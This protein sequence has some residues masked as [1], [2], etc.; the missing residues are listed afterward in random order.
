MANLMFCILRFDEVVLKLVDVLKV[1]RVLV[2]YAF[3]KFKLLSCTA[4]AMMLYSISVTAA[5]YCLFCGKP[6]IFS[7]GKY[8]CVNQYCRGVSRSN[9]GSPMGTVK[10]SI[11]TPGYSFSIQG[12]GCSMLPT[13][14]PT[15]PFQPQAIAQLQPQPQLQLQPQLQPQPNMLLSQQTQQMAVASTTAPSSGDTTL[16]MAQPQ[17]SSSKLSSTLELLLKDFEIHLQRHSDLNYSSNSY[18][19]LLKCFV[20]TWTHLS[21]NNQLN[22]VQTIR[23]LCHDLDLCGI[24]PP[25]IASS[26]PIFNNSLDTLVNDLL[27]NNQVLVAF[28]SENTPFIM[29]HVRNLEG[30]SASL[31]AIQV[32]GVYQAGG[33]DTI[34]SLESLRN[35]LFQLLHASHQEGD[36][37]AILIFRSTTRSIESSIKLPI[38]DK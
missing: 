21:T 20:A 26:K 33:F 36:N 8:L 13:F 11:Q 23:R 24:W 31:A 3:L 4:L 30:A 7:M 1:V 35:F 14:L 34:L 38:T 9:M 15:M 17:K 25:E 6:M 12:S 32:H 16:A 10:F 5:S 28:F 29:L 27:G 22:S 19:D 18:Y 2:M 37:V